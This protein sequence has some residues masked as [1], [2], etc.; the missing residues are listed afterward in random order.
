MLLQQRPQD[1]EFS[2]LRERARADLDQRGAQGRNLCAARSDLIVAAIMMAC[3][4]FLGMAVDLTEKW[5]AFSRQYESWEL[6]ELVLTLSLMSLVFAWYS[7]RRW[8][9][10]RAEARRSLELSRR[11][12]EEAERLATAEQQAALASRTKSEFLANISHELRTPLN[13]INGFSEIICRETFGPVGD[14]K[15]LEY[16]ADINRCGM[17]LLA[18]INDLLDISKIE[19]GRLELREEQAD[20]WQALDSCVALVRQRARSGG[21]AIDCRATTPLPAVYADPQKLKQI[22]INLLSNAVKF[23]PAGGKVA[24]RSWFD[25]QDGYVI[26]VSDT[27]IGIAPEDIPKALTPFRRGENAL[28]GEYEGTGLGL[29]LTKSFVELHGGALE[30]ASE[31]GAGTTVTVHLPAARAMPE[32]ATGT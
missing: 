8:R 30:L 5:H 15:Y 9:E 12:L 6:D 26:E 28:A 7:I 21:V 10:Y 3:A 24:V 20:L 25:A 32:L 18:L 29:S 31:L 4:L 22:L 14:P 27:G 19:A 13:A 11:L 1:S 2:A 17:H 23:T 16:V